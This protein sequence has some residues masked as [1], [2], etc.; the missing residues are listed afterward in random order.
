MSVKYSESRERKELYGLLY[1]LL[2]FCP[3]ELISL[4]VNYMLSFKIVLLEGSSGGWVYNV[5]RKTWMDFPARPGFD[6]PH[7]CCLT[8][9]GDILCVGHEISSELNR[10]DRK[11]EKWCDSVLIPHIRGDFAMAYSNQTLYLNGGREDRRLN[12]TCEFHVFTHQYTPCSGQ[13]QMNQSR[14]S[15][16]LAQ[17]FDGKWFV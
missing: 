17:T 4:L 1:D 2:D 8:E 15:H 3:N 11:T 9:E 7:F 16:G 12:D 5:D 10:F 13:A 14:F 6:S